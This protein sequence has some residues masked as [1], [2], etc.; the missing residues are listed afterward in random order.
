MD[1]SAFHSLSYGLY[2]VSSQNKAGRK[3]G[4]VVNTFQQVTSRPFQVSVALNKENATLAAI[5]ESGRFCVTVLEQDTPME[6]IGRFGFHSSLDTDKF[7][8]VHFEVDNDGFPALLECGIAVFSC[9][10]VN[11]VDMGSHVVV[12]GKVEDARSLSTSEPLTYA[13]YHAVK[14]GKTPPKAS[15][16]VGDEPQPVAPAATEASGQQRWGWRCT[17]CGYTLEGYPDGLPAD[18]TCPVCGVG[19]EM[20]ERVVLD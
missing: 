15:S 6:L 2:V 7:D 1:T 5:Q 16:Y 13:Y 3:C 12:F 9:E 4:C 17:V 20:F 10:V 19:P 14:K 8:G 11:T 18:F